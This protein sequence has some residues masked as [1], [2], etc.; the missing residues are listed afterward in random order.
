MIPR[1]LH[2]TLPA[3]PAPIM[4]KC[5]ESVLKHCEGWELRTYQSP[6]DANDW[7]MTRRLWGY[8]KDNAMQADL[9]RLEAL[10]NLGGIY[11]DAD[12]ELLHPL[13]DLLDG[14]PFAAWE[15]ANQLC[16]AVIGAPPKHPAIRDALDVLEVQIQIGAP[17]VGPKSL[18]QSWTER[19]DVRLLP[20]ESFYPYGY[21]EKERAA[22]DFTEVEGCYG[23]H[24]WA[25]T[26]F[27][28]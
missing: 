28:P 16:N 19:D 17:P 13:D 1:I 3:T 15:D 14:G 10:W 24:H 5:W 7:P 4:D 27:K 18:T 22:D 6:R 11:L 2:R 23:V 20:R 25:A 21:W 26:W 12:V 9:V 8:C